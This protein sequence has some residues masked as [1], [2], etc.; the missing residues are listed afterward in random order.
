[1]E[2]G[3]HG[4]TEHQGSGTNDQEWRG[5]QGI[6]TAYLLE[7]VPEFRHVMDLRQQVGLR[8]KRT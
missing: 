4:K 6:I 2:P 8:Q 1:M 5:A 3:G 7:Q